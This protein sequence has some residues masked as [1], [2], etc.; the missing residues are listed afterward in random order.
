MLNACNGN[1]FDSLSEQIYIVEQEYPSYY[2]QGK[3][4]D[5][6]PNFEH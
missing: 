3:D 4:S 1:K 5:I 6:L 2:Y